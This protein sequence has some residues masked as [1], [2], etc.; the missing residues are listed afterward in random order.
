MTVD[1]ELLERVTA[2]PEWAAGVMRAAAIALNTL[3]D[4]LPRCKHCC[5]ETGPDGDSTALGARSVLQ[6]AF[7]EP[8]DYSKLGDLLLSAAHVQRLAD[9]G[10]KGRADVLGIDADDAKLMGTGS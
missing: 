9:L 8:L 10:G 5:G 2:D 6:S 3:Q 7:A 1:Q 4:G